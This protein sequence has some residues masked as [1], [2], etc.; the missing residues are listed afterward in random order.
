VKKYEALLQDKLREI[1]LLE[2]SLA[3]LQLRTYTYAYR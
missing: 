1:S 3:H 2:Q